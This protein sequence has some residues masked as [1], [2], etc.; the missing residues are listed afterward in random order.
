MLKTSKE[1]L[2]FLV[3]LESEVTSGDLELSFSEFEMLLF[4]LRKVSTIVNR[5]DRKMC[6]EEITVHSSISLQTHMKLMDL[7]RIPSTVFLEKFQKG[8]PSSD[9]EAQAQRT[10]V[11]ASK[12]L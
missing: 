7:G 2:A 6:G 12:V 11:S 1:F 10:R 4:Y 9:V 3:L 5:K 8:E